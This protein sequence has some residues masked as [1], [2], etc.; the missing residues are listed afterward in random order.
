MAHRFRLFSITSCFVAE[1]MLLR[2]VGAVSETRPFGS[3]K[4]PTNATAG[5]GV[6]NSVVTGIR[7]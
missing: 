1:T 3:D 5:E 2:D 6:R 7:H 4:E